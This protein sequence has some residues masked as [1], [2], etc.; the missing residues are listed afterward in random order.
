[1]A[2]LPPVDFSAAFGHI[3]DLLG[4]PAK[5]GKSNTTP[6]PLKYLVDWRA[7]INHAPK[8]VIVRGAFY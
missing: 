7:A 2:A 8:Y 1:L 3:V 5:N 6:D 4:A